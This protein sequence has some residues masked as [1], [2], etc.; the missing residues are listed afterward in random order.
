[1]GSDPNHGLAGRRAIFDPDSGEGVSVGGAGG[2]T[3][4]RR[5]RGGIGIFNAEGAKG[6]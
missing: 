1:M 6:R 3:W 5:W 2:A 4:R